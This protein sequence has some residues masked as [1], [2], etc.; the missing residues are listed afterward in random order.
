VAWKFFKSKPGSLESHLHGTRRPWRWRDHD[1]FVTQAGDGPLVI[2]VHGIYAGSSSYEY[3]KLFPLLAQ[4]YRVIA[5]D[6]LGSGLSER[7]DIPYN[8]DVFVDQIVD[9]IGEFGAPAAL[10][11]SS[12]GGAFATRAAARLGEKIQ[13]L[14]LVCPTGLAGTLDGPAKSGQK[15]ATK[16]IMAPV[17]GQA[18]FNLLASRASLGWFLRNQAYAHA[19]SVTPAVLD[20]YWLATHQPGSRYVPAYFVGGGLNLSIADDLPRVTGPVLV[21]WGEYAKMTSPVSTAP[22]YSELARNGRLVTFANSRLLP[23]EEEPERFFETFEAFLS[24]PI[25]QR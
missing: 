24:E 11:A 20:Q 5:F 3:R 13:R 15:M 4:R 12:M 10:V 22:Q 6:L 8:A 16:L 7:P 1:I 2:L 23:H 14:V 19:S 25:P 17:I 21:A 9:A 18:F